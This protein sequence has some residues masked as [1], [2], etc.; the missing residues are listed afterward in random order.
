MPRIRRGLRRAAPPSAGPGP[1][2]PSCSP[3]RLVAWCGP[4]SGASRHA[5]A[6]LASIGVPEPMQPRRELLC[7][8]R[9]VE[10]RES[11]PRQPVG[12][13]DWPRR[14][15]RLPVEPLRCMP[16]S[17][18]RVPTRFRELFRREH[19]ESSRPAGAT[20]LRST[21]ASSIRTVALPINDFDQERAK[22]AVTSSGSSGC[23]RGA[24][25]TVCRGHSRTVATTCASR[26]S[27]L[28]RTAA[29]GL[30]SAAPKTLSVSS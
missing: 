26:P 18:R 17:L 28:S 24:V 4:R 8:H 11:S 5:A 29:P 10:V 1:S 19:Q 15:G 25:A 9:L 3:V 13:H 16:L 23:G 2:P 12:D 6:F 22:S 14:P 30:P 21:A 20:V 27:H 7:G